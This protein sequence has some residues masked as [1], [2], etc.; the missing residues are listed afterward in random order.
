MERA[1]A[2]ADQADGESVANFLVD[3]RE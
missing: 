2:L 1:Q 3:D